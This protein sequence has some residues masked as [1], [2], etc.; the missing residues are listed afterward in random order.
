[1][2]QSQSCPRCSAANS[3]SARFCQNCGA[4]LTATLIQGRTVILPAGQHQPT[5]AP[6]F[7]PK[8]IAQRARSVFNT[9]QTFVGAPPHGANRSN[10]REDT[11]LDCDVSGSMA[12]EFDHGVAKI[13]A[14]RRAAVNLVLQKHQIDPRDR[15]GVITFNDRADLQMALACVGDDKQS[16]IRKLQSLNAGGGT[17]I[18]EGLVLA[19][20]NFDWSRADVVRRIVLLTDGRDGGDPIPTASD[21]KRQGVVIDVIGI[22]ASP[23][24]V[25]E[26]L[27]KRV[28]STIQGELRYRFIKDHRTLVSHF[29]QL[30]TKTSTSP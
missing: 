17:D 18:N 30:A 21:L 25:N 28:A 24:G 11:L 6:P 7:D 8:A 16:L 22:G 2:N 9:G 27:L 23:A 29:T 10:Q 20:E 26:D 19:R 4:V 14:L 13:E 3:S 1:M 12:D 5:G 15:V